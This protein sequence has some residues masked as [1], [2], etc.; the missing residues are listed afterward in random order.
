MNNHSPQLENNDYLKLFNEYCDYRGTGYVYTWHMRIDTG[1][2]TS[3][4]NRELN[5]LVKRGL[6]KK[7]S[8]GH[9]YTKFVKIQCHD[10]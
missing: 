1:I 6:L 4:L 9:S 10:L 2:P 8:P 7:E 5:K 3:K